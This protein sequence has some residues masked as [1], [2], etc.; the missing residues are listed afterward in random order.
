MCSHILYFQIFSHYY[1]QKGNSQRYKVF[2]LLIL[3]TI[4]FQSLTEDVLRQTERER[5]LQKRYS[6][7]QFRMSLLQ[8]TK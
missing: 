2:I 3:I 4:I 6:D 5:E 1:M 7:L 8:V